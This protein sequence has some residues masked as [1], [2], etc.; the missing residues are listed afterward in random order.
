MP[1]IHPSETKNAKWKPTAR[2]T[3]T[4]WTV[5]KKSSMSFAGT[6][7]FSVYDGQGRLAFR[8]D[9]YSRK[10]K[11]LIGE[12]LLTDSIGKPLLSLQPR[13]LS[14]RDRWRA[15]IEV[16]ESTK[17]HLFDMRRPSFVQSGLEIAEVFMGRAGGGGADYIIKGCFK[18]R[19]CTVR[20]RDGEILATISPKKA[21]PTV[22]LGED[23]F[24]LLLEPGVS[25][26]LLVSFIVA[27]D[28][29][30]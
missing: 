24:E 16:E 2:K 12:L 20:G 13:V 28:R 8:V 6:D 25:T 22:V 3:T 23:V 19:C 1:K 15:Y 29:I 11:F 9:N 5:W 14:L 7:G 18:K 30:C 17:F 10:N 4:A 21:N 27:M 26:E